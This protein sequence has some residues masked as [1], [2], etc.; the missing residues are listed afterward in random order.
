M[1]RRTRLR[2][3]QV[4]RQL[5]ENGPPLG[6]APRLADDDFPTF[7]DAATLKVG[8]GTIEAEC[9]HPC[10]GWLL[11]GVFFNDHHMG[12]SMSGGY[13]LA[14][15]HVHGN[16]PVSFYI[17]DEG[18][19]R[20]PLLGCGRSG[21]KDQEKGRGMRAKRIGRPNASEVEEI[22]RRI[23]D[24]AT[25]LFVDH[26]YAST[27]IERVAAVA[28][29]GKQTIYRRYPTKEIL[30]SACVLEMA[31]GMLDV[32]YVWTENVLEPLEGLRRIC[33]TTLDLAA[34]PDVIALCRIV[35]SEAPRFPVLAERVG[36]D[37][38][39]PHQEAIRSHVRAAVQLGHLR[40][41]LPVETA[42]NTLSGS[43]TS[44]LLVRNLLG[45]DALPTDEERQAYFDDAWS[46]FLRGAKAP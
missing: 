20:A 36:R 15:D 31:R 38:I 40:S 42:V 39:E 24:T 8:L 3:D 32:A 7:S 11:S 22:D 45:G 19:P 10:H 25:R 28:K 5:R 29:V 16:G 6:P 17:S 23:L 46:I 34:R 44:W 9:G 1:P 30:F 18:C 35:V 43:I 14:L 33:R 13:G 21:Q 2:A 41:D 4:R 27:S 26:G 12:T 37:V